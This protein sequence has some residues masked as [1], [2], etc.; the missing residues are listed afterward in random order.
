M[1]DQIQSH[2]LFEKQFKHFLSFMKI[3]KSDGLCRV[4]FNFGK[5]KKKSQVISVI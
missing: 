2:T 1:K 5:S 3:L 4:F